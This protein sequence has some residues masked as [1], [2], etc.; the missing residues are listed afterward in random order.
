MAEKPITS[1]R[2]RGIIM[3]PTPGNNDLAA[4]KNEI[5]F[6]LP[7]DAGVDGPI[8]LATAVADRG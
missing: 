1:I 6:A 8:L 4:D 2:A 7:L 5:F 3:I